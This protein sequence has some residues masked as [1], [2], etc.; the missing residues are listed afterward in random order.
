ML[1]A[2]MLPLLVVAL[3]VANDLRIDLAEQSA[4]PDTRAV[5]LPFWQLLTP[6]CVTLAHCLLAFG[7]IAGFVWRK[8]ERRS[9]R[10]VLAAFALSLPLQ[11]LPRLVPLS[12]QFA[13][14]PEL[15]EQMEP[16]FAAAAPMMAIGCMIDLLPLVLSILVGL[17]RAGLH[18]QATAPDQPAGATV[19]FVALLQIALLCSVAVGVATSLPTSNWLVIGLVLLLAHYS[20]AATISFGLA[21]PMAQRPAWS[22]RAFLASAIVLLL[23]GVA[24][25]A[26]GLAH[27]EIF[28]KPLL[29]FGEREGLVSPSKLGIDL[30]L[31]AGRALVTAVAAND[32]LARS[33]DGAPAANVTSGAA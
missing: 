7:A 3:L 22:R 9:R 2:A 17:A 10:V 11:V 14:T 31:F 18:R 33:H 19:A 8:N 20:A 4:D 23:P 5:V 28:D 16:T 24:D 21:R 15:R 25:L 27:L 12:W 6:V 32:L 1:G 29:G 26:V 13:L 30:L